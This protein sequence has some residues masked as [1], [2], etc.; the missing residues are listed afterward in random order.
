MTGR[1]SSPTDWAALI[2]TSGLAAIISGVLSYVGVAAKQGRE[3]ES[4]RCQIAA[5]FLQDETVSPYI[6]IATRR[7]LSVVSARTLRRCLE[8]R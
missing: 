1:R 8:A 5:Q 4:Q 2:I 7:T 6:D 3:R